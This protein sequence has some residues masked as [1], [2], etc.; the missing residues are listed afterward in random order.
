M[1]RILNP[2][3]NTLHR[4]IDDADSLRT[5]C[6]SLRHVTRGEARAVSESELETFESVD[7]CG[8]CFEGSGGY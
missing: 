5:P 7:R 1:R 2:H 6:G 8:N 3:T 4:A